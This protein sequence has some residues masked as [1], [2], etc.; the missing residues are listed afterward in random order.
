MRLAAWGTCV[1]LAMAGALVSS[2]RGQS[3]LP[4]DNAELVRMFQ[5]DQ[6]DRK[7]GLHGIDWSLV[8]PRD[9]ARLERTRALYVS[10]A[11][12]TG[13]DWF[14]AALILQHSSD[15]DDYLLA[16]EMCVAALAQGEKGYAISLA[17]AS[18]DRF[19]MSIGRK[20]RFGTQYEPAD[21]PGKYRLAPTDLLVTD[22]LRE[23][24]RTPSLAEARDS[25]GQFD[26]KAQEVPFEAALREAQ[27]ATRAEPLKSY[28][29]GPFGEA[30]GRH[31]I[32]WLNECSQK[33]QQN[34]W[35]FDMLITIGAT[36]AVTEVRYEPVT[37]TTECFA[38]LV[39]AQVFAPP[40][41]PGLVV[42]AGIRK[43]K[44]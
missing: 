7:P 35:I 28:M 4:T 30:F 42:P 6:D 27:E 14:H 25:A 29:A 9:D 15:A 21:E 8:K 26:K 11:L 16:H 1:A 12:R 41:K 20:Q 17:A 13:A 22:Q 10:G 19:L 37:P 5:E 36:G 39:K 38:R 24:L 32:D 23:A 40:P 44:E 3:S 31:Y 2:V 43:P 18:E 34:A 33:T